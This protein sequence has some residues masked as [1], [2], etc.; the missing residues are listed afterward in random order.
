M[1]SWPRSWQDLWMRKKRSQYSGHR[2]PA[3][4]I[5]HSVWLYYRFSLSF[6]DIE[7][8]LAAR[9]VA[10]TYES[11]RFWCLKFGQSMAK[12]IRRRQGRLGDTWHLDEV[13]VSIKGVRHYLWRAVDQDGDVLDILV[14]KKR[15]G[16]AAKRFFRR[17][18][19]GL[20]YVPRQI[21]TDKLGSYSVAHKA[22][23]R[24]V[25]HVRDK[26]S[27]N[28]AENSHQATRQRERQMRRFKSA[29]HMQR[30]LSV[31][32]PINNVFRV[33]RHLMKAKN[34]RI[35]RDRGF[36]LWDEVAYAQRPA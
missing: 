8:M 15:S 36:R 33:G 18:L 5:S 3:E 25:E 4:I 26:G 19:K 7:E 20:R 32:G 14:Q 22:F 16:N 21:V 31:H 12:G 34:Y 29:G 28:R 35:L 10:V 24:T 11:I 1:E 17:L 13:F 9:G 2:F 6:R 30:F 23:M 27:N